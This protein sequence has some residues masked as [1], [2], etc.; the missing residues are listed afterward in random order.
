M[1]FLFRASMLVFKFSAGA[2]TDHCAEK[3]KTNM[4]SRNKKLD[5]LVVIMLQETNLETVLAQL[6]EHLFLTILK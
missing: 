3:L 4:L 6:K 5:R 2:I 1:V